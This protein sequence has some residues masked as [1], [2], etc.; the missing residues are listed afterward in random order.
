MTSLKYFRWSLAAPIALPLLL[1]PLWFLGMGGDG[2]FSS[3]IFVLMMSVVFGG[4]QY[5]LVL[6]P[7]MLWLLGKTPSSRGQIAWVLV[8]PLIYAPVQCLGLVLLHAA[9]TNNW[10]DMAWR[11]ALDF[12]PFALGVAYCYVALVLAGYGV[13]R[14]TQR[15]A[16][17]ST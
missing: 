15:I 10:T 9:T 6:V 3:I 16:P 2:F 7:L 1:L 11:S 8:T 12:S 13:L 4:A 14:W 5:L 17:A